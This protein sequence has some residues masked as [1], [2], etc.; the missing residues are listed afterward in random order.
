MKLQLTTINQVCGNLKEVKQ[1][2]NSD[3]FDHL[4]PV[5]SLI[6]VPPYLP[7]KRLIKPTFWH[8]SE[9]YQNDL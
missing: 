2:L 1:C 9:A 6:G 3:N 4:R 5:P 8:Y 7:V